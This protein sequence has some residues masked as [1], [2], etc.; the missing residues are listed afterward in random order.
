M[1]E[2]ILWYN[3]NK[4]IVLG[5]L[6]IVAIIIVVVQGLD[7]LAGRNK[8]QE[9]SISFGNNTESSLNTVVLK[10]EK[11]PLTG[12][13]I[14]KGQKELLST[15]DK[16]GE[17]CNNKQ[18]NEAYNLLSEDCKNQMYPTV[19]EFKKNYY[20]KIFAEKVKNISTENWVGD[21]FKVKFTD[22]ALSTGIYNSQSAIQDYITIVEDKNDNVKLNING[23]IGK[24]KIDKTK[25]VYDI[26]IQVLEKYKYMDYEIYAYEVQNNSKNII[27]MND[28]ENTDT[29]YLEDENGIKYYAYINEL[30][31]AN[32]MVY[33]GETKK[34]DIKYY[35]KYS[36]TREITT[37]N[38]T[39]IALG[40]NEM[41]NIEINM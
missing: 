17:Y 35:N 15:L 18:I 41:A 1:R 19:T 28:V 26:K 11:S 25:E 6:G 8:E 3:R 16:F 12:Q 27:L 24:E 34:I 36:S 32:L 20:D 14:S 38:F 4:K 37:I 39:E 5:S 30:S 23:Y 9:N 10:D 31:E 2:I 33:P 7:W 22:D 29:M 40:G 13:S 21:I